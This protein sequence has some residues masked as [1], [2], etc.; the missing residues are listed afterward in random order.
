[1]FSCRFFF[2]LKTTCF[3]FYFSLT[4]ESVVTV[5]KK[6]YVGLPVFPSRFL[7]SGGNLFRRK[8]FFSRKETATQPYAGNETSR[9]L[10]ESK[11]EL[12]KI[13]LEYRRKEATATARV[14]KGSTS[15]GMGGRAGLRRWPGS[16][17]Q[18]GAG[19]RE[20]PG[21]EVEEAGPAGLQGAPIVR[22]PAPKPSDVFFPREGICDSSAPACGPRESTRLAPCSPGPFYGGPPVW[23]FPSRAPHRKAI[24]Q[25]AVKGK[26]SGQAAAHMLQAKAAQIRL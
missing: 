6:G 7:I 2:F 9:P 12:V 11:G 3:K 17:G 20:N 19:E 14:T 22:V 26:T 1:M 8:F 23:G 4:R 18:S 5:K 21:S 25:R 24:S 13:R 15:C 10:L 16:G